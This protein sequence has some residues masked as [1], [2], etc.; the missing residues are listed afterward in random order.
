MVGT[1]HLGV[2]V[3]APLGQHGSLER[4]GK[5]GPSVSNARM[6][7]LGMTLLAEQGRALPQ[8]SRMIGPVR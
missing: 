4:T 7:R 3:E 8:Q 6:A 5:P 2:T 1:V